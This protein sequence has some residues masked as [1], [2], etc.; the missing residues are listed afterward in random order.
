MGQHKVIGKRLVTLTLLV[1]LLAVTL[2]LGVS[3]VEASPSTFY[4]PDDYPTIQ[5]AVDTAK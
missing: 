5:A 3:K 4:V 2:P 1:A